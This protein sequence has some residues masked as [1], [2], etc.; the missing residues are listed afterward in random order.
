[1]KSGRYAI[2]KNLGRYLLAVESKTN[3]SENLILRASSDLV[4]L[5][6][7]VERLLEKSAIS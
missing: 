6:K 1:M 3:A 5:F 4:G 2:V 7:E